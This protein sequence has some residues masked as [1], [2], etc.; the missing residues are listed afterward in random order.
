MRLLALAQDFWPG[1]SIAL[2]SK[3]LIDDFAVLGLWQAHANFFR[4]PRS[5]S[6]KLPGTA[7]T[8]SCPA[9]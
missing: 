1:L 6:R 9:W 4:L 3:L 2:L 5:L 8:R 7:M